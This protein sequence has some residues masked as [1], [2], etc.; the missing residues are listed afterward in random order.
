MKYKV[1]SYKDLY[2]DNSFVLTKEF[3]SENKIYLINQQTN[4]DYS[5]YYR[6]KYNRSG[7]YR[8]NGI[9]L[10]FNIKK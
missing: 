1:K 4:K 8:P 10:L 6:M 5:I 7:V 2:P 3:I 9:Y